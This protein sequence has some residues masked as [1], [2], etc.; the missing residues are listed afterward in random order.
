MGHRWRKTVPDDC[1]AGGEEPMIFTC[2]AAT[3]KRAFD[4]LK[5]DEPKT[6]LL[7]TAQAS[8]LQFRCYTNDA[9]GS[10]CIDHTMPAE[11]EVPGTATVSADALPRIC[12]YT[13]SETLRFNHHEWH[14][15]MVEGH[16]HRHAVHIHAEKWQNPALEAPTDAHGYEIPASQF[17]TALKSVLFAAEQPSD[18]GAEEQKRLMLVGALFHRHDSEYR[19]V[20]T[21]GLRMAVFT[22]PSV[23]ELADTEAPIPMRAMPYK[24]CVKMVGLIESLKPEVCRLRFAENAVSFEA[25]D[26]VLRCLLQKNYP[27]YLS[28]FERETARLEVKVNREKLLWALRIIHVDDNPAYR[29]EFRVSDG[30]LTVGNNTHLGKSE[31]SVPIQYE[32]PDT[33]AT[34]NSWLF[35]EALLHTDA[36][37]ITLWMQPAASRLEPI[38]LDLELAQNFRCLVMPLK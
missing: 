32:G 36:T 31:A 30:Q 17:G 3:L 34:A 12:E 23:R 5:L 22:L 20:T 16:Q 35:E 4:L 14:G 6:H 19:I 10:F 27:D 9:Y 13:T 8:Q 18:S 21:D 28:I 15:C 37:D 33:A 2:N 24:A 1:P 11:V 29:T 38:F 26:V 7:I 25:E